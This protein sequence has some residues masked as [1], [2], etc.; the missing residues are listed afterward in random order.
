MGARDDPGPPRVVH[1]GPD[2]TATQAQGVTWV[3]P[4]E[5]DVIVP[6]SQ[7]IALGTAQVG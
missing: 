6:N 2:Y 1:G 4:T 5:V 3:N 7:G